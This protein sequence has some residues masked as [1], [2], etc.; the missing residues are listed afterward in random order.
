LP[1]NA[2]EPAVVRSIG[3]DANDK[4]DERRQKESMPPSSRNA[5]QR[6]TASAR[7][8]SL[9]RRQRR[10]TLSASGET[11]LISIKPV[12]AGT[13]QRSELRSLIQV[14]AVVPGGDRIRLAAREIE[15]DRQ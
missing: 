6:D 10:A 13:P 11:A 15:D 14:K 12:V 9:T 4:R 3:G 7:A 1:T 5:G 2:H 8:H